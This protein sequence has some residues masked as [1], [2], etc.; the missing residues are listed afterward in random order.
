MRRGKN[1]RK[2]KGKGGKGKGKGKKM[3]NLTYEQFL[4]AIDNKQMS[5]DGEPSQVDQMIE[6]KCGK[7]VKKLGWVYEYMKTNVE[8]YGD[9]L[10][11]AADKEDAVRDQCAAKSTCQ[12]NHKIEKKKCDKQWQLM[13]KASRLD[14][15]EVADPITLGK[16]EDDI[17]VCFA[18]ALKGQINSDCKAEGE[19][20]YN[21]I[22]AEKPDWANDE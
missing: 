7:K 18:V 1:W 19:A 12:M 2:G 20:A 11:V 3:R 6:K 21:T 8:L 9:Y 5:I 14:E 13:V 15:G 16:T 4:L 17:G 22:M 10:D